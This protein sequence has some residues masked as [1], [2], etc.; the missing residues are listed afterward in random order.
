MSTIAIHSVGAVPKTYSDLNKKLGLRP[1]RTEAELDRATKVV[2]MLATQPRLTRDQADYLEVL[3]N[4]IEVYEAEHYKAQFTDIEP[5]DALRFLLGEHGMSGSDLG[6]LLG[7]PRQLGSAILR[8]ERQLSKA[9]VRK[10]AAHFSVEA[11]VFLG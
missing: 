8:G 11:G 3:S 5:L 7:G 9:H 1:I 10:L 4:L 6:R 2:N